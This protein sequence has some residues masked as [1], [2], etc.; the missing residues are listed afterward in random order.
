MG[1]FAVDR[2]FEVDASTV[3]H[4]LCEKDGNGSYKL[5]TR[6]LLNWGKQNHLF[7]L[8]EH[9]GGVEFVKNSCCQ[10]FLDKTWIGKT[11]LSLVVVSV[12]VY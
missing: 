1:Q 11:K 10:S 3:L 8:A 4:Q 5:L 6:Q 7:S 9:S 2:K 12:D